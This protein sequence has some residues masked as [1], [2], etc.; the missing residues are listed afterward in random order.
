GSVLIGVG[1]ILGTIGTV[2]LI[3]NR[4]AKQ[5]ER[6]AKKQRAAIVPTGLGIAGRF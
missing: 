5:G 4:G 1:A 6:A 3:R 2:A